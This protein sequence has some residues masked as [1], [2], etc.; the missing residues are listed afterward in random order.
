[1]KRNFTLSI[2][3]SLVQSL[4]ENKYDFQTMY[5]YASHQLDKVIILRHDVDAFPENS[6]SVA[7]FENSF[8]V[9]G[10]YY[11]KT[12][13][14]SYNQKIIEQIIR[15]GNEIG[16]HYE[17]LA[18]AHGDYESAIRSF[19]KN[20]EYLRRLYPVKTICMD[21]NAWSKWN[22]LDLWKK[23]DYRNY[24]I[25]AEPYLDLDFNKVL[26]LTD[27][28]RKW[29]GVRFSIWDKVDSPFRYYNKSTSDIIRDIGNNAL[30]GQIMI[31]THPQRWNDRLW[32]WT[33]ELVLQ[34]VKNV[35]KAMIV[36]REG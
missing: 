13:P 36:R 11:F 20:L 35:V 10:T 29:N 12:K 5:E 3:Q 24:G 9:K 14:I 8:G 32:P 34:N 33:K 15:M 30:P 31:N 16:Y 2:Y 28:G 22:N 1:L 27:T 21:G 26:Y 18:D 7:K 6:L 23:F 17:D 4:V 25:V 19:E